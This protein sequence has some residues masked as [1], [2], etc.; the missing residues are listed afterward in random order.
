[1]SGELRIQ[2]TK[3]RAVFELNRELL[4]QVKLFEA[5]SGGF[6]NGGRCII[7]KKQR[8]KGFSQKFL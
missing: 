2:I 8:R 1:V 7:D 3:G 6:S 5:D 4:P